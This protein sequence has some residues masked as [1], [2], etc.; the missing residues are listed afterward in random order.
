MSRTVV[1]RSPRLGEHRRGEIQELALVGSN[2]AL[3]HE[4]KNINQ[5]RLLGQESDCLQHRRPTKIEIH[6]I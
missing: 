1:A 2:A 3:V 5:K 4:E 6:I